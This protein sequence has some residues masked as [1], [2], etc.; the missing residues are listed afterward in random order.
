MVSKKRRA[1][2]VQP[3]PKR[4]QRCLQVGTVPG[5]A[6]I[7]LIAFGRAGVLAGKNLHEMA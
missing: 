5:V 3:V 1:P 2:K 6:A 7:S 4:R